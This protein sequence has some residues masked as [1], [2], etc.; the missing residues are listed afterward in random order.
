M[1]IFDSLYRS[2]HGG[3]TGI[4]YRIIERKRDY[5]RFVV[6]IEQGD[7]EKSQQHYADQH[8]FRFG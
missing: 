2:G 6:S 3:V 4:E 1:I 5:F 7:E 8:W